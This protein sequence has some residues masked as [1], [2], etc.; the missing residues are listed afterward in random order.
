MT[1]GKVTTRSRKY[2]MHEILAAG[3]TYSYTAPANIAVYIIVLLVGVVIGM[4]MGKR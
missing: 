1:C 4:R 3:T 2:E